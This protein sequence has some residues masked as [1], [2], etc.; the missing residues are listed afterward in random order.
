MEDE[1]TGLPAQQDKDYFNEALTFEEVKE[2]EDI[3]KIYHQN[4]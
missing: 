2:R 4:T 1:Y 3:L